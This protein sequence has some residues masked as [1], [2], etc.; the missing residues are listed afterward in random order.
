MLLSCCVGYS[1]HYTRP[2]DSSTLFQQSLIVEFPPGQLKSVVTA[3]SELFWQLQQLL[4]KQFT[5]L[6]VELSDRHAMHK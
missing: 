5:E 3:D 2:L 4:I 6:A 1:T